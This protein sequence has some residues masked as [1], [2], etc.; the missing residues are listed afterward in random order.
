MATSLRLQHMAIV[1]PSEDQELT[2]LYK[3][4]DGMCSLSHGFNAAQK[5]GLSGDVISRG[6]EISK[7]MNMRSNTASKF[8]QVFNI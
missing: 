4:V 6:K 8:V 2:F 5:A 3:L 1:E 7:T